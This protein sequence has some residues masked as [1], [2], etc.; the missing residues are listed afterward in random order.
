[1]LEVLTLTVAISKLIPAELCQLYM[2]IANIEV[3]VASQISDTVK[4]RLRGSP[5]CCGFFG[6]T[7]YYTF[8]V[9]IFLLNLY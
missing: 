5:C 9:A 4:C 7:H 2:Y 3:P 1:M 8:S 6:A